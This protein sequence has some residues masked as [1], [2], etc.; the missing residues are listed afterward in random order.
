M[1]T[2]SLLPHAEF[3]P[4]PDRE[5]ATHFTYVHKRTVDT[6]VGFKNVPKNRSIFRKIFPH[7]LLMFRE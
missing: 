4:N 3:G 2:V 7:D 5:H 1:I 6:K